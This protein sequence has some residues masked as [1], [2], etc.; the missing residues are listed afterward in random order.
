MKTYRIGIAGYGNLGRGA[1]LA[2][3]EQPDLRI[4]FKCK[5]RAGTVVCQEPFS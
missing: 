3:R 2:L 4:T 1:E 5:D